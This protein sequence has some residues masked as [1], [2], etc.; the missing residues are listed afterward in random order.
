MTAPMAAADAN[1]QGEE[2]LSVTVGM[3]WAIKQGAVATT[4]MEGRAE[5]IQGFL[6]SGPGL[7]CSLAMT[8]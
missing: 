4:V 2:T 7:V 1:A 6:C 5:A 3:T 8:G